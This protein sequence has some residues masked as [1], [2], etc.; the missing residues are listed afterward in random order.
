MSNQLIQL[1]QVSKTFHTRGVSVHALRSVDFEIY[2]MEIIGLV[3]I[4]G[5]GK[6]TLARILSALSSPDHGELFFQGKNYKNMNRGERFEFKRH[7]QMVFQDPYSSLNP[8]MTVFDL[9]AEPLFTHWNLSQRETEKKVQQAL[10]SVGLDLLTLSCYPEEL[11]GGAR[12]RVAIARALILEPSLLILDEAVS[13]LDASV[14]AQVINL[15]KESH[16]K[17]QMTILF[18]SHD[19][20][21]VKYL[22]TK[23]AV[24]HQGSIIEIQPT[25]KLFESPLHPLTKS[26]LDALKPAEKTEAL[27]VLPPTLGTDASES[28]EDLS[29]CVHSDLCPHVH[30]ACL[31][32][33]PD[34]VSMGGDRFVSCYLHD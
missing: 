17:K 33:P 32:S 8:K 21:V 22:S 27:H 26:M 4:S 14:Q 1:S 25:D 29:R 15:L 34:M 16:Q 19:L 11:S 28:A 7:V 31:T 18:I 30:S 24:L 5:S 6:T 9:V 2:P 12:Q 13:T 23:T 3:G 10:S 20:A